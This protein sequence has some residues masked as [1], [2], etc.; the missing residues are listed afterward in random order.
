MQMLV[1]LTYND[2]HPALSLIMEAEDV[3]TNKENGKDI[4]MEQY[5]RAVSLRSE[6]ISE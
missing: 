4:T 6:A 3:K 1:D 5:K 2:I